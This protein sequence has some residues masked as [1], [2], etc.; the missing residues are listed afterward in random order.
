MMEG[1]LPFSMYTNIAFFIGTTC[2]DFDWFWNLASQNWKG[3]Q[4]QYVKCLVLKMKKT[5]I[6]SIS[7]DGTL[8]E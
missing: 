8:K 2:I 4:R 6:D 5:S 1:T 7:C 3:Q